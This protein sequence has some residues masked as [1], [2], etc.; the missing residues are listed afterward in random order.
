MKA[1]QFRSYGSPEVM[2]VA[3]VP[4][5]VPGEGQVLVE[6]HAAALNPLDW[7][8]RAG[9]LQQWVPLTLPV[10]AGGDFSGRVV[11][12]G[13]GAGGWQR[14]DEV[15][16]SATVLFG[17]SGSLAE[18]AL[19]NAG[20]VAHKPHG[21]THA[22]AAAAVLSGVS[23][24]QAMDDT[25]HPMPGTRLLIHGGAGGVGSLAIQYA[26]HRGAHV[27]T[28]ARGDDQEYVRQLGA[29]ET[30]DFERQAFET[31]L[32]DYDAVLDTV[33]G[34]TLVKSYQVCKPG[35]IILT[36]VEQPNEALSAEYHLKALLQAGD[37]STSRLEL[38]AELLDS[39]V[40]RVRVGK[41][42]TL[43]Q[44]KHAFAY[45]ERGHTRGKVVI[46]VR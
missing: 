5:P 11:Q 33:G 16:G 29:D 14:G 2:E 44:A 7:K 6:V 13:P 3:S 22:E 27:A 24:V 31:L 46:Q 1:V 37:V 39:Q 35:G 19:A 18:Y 36:L 28:T 20:Q 12:A 40:I 23:A 41:S 10:T 8:V 45:L 21:L 17:G 26:K 42:F 4:T 38:L 30:L 43:D 32:R 34:E 9:Y 15:Y 25:L